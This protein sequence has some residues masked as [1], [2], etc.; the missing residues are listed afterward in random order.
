MFPCTIHIQ[1]GSIIKMHMGLLLKDSALVDSLNTSWRIASFYLFIHLIERGSTTATATATDFRK[2]SEIF[3]I[4]VR[5]QLP[6][7]SV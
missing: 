2:V 4:F 6:F 5:K 3:L 1:G 7:C